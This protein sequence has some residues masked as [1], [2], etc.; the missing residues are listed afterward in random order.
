MTD[1]ARAVEE[2]S[3]ELRRELRLGDLVLAQV[4]LIVGATWVGVAG[5]LGDAHVV[6]WLLAAVLFFAPLAAVV[7]FLNDCWALE[8]GL[9]QWAK[10]GFGEA[11]G[12]LVGWNLALWAVV[13]M[14]SLGLEV[15]TLL[16]YA[17]GPRAAWMATSRAFIALVSVLLVGSLAA[18]CTVG[19]HFGKWVHNAGG[20]VGIGTYAVL[21]L[22]PIA[23]IAAGGHVAWHPLRAQ[24]PPVNLLSL[25]ILGKMGFGAFSGFE[26][27][28]IFAGEARAPVRSMRRSVW[29]AGPVVVAMFVLGT[30]GVLAFTPPDDI[31]LIAPLPQAVTAGTRALPAL[32]WLVPAA[33]LGIAFRATAWGSAAFAGISRLPMVAGWDGLLPSVFTRLHPRW[34]TPVFSVAFLAVVALALGAVGMIGVGAQE[35]WQ[36]FGN[37]CLVFYA[38]TY[39][40][41]FAI[42]ILAPRS[43]PRRPGLLLR[44]ACTSGFAM[45]VLFIVLSVVPIVRVESTRAFTAKIAVVI[46]AAN[47]L[48]AGLWVAAK[49]RRE[50]RSRPTLDA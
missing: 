45:T 37:A 13:N 27:V 25:N 33:S 23:N 17:L 18:A 3:A 7:V 15:A 21:V 20:A 49:R 41:M 11:W 36:L 32:A 26:Y 48:G 28:A 29:L 40:V 43:L 6:Y 39:L 38:F 46:V 22:L 44:V 10:L 9:Y 8:G 34:R 24:A 42:P 12:F 19:L 50:A 14:A 1:A 30:S 31:D 2:R 5:R 35:A 4:V 16:A 47:A